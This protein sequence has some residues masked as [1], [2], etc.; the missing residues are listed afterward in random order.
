LRIKPRDDTDSRRQSVEQE[1]RRA[2]ELGPLRDPVCTDDCPQFDALAGC[3]RDCAEAPKRLSSEG[4]K[5][6][7]EPLVAPLVFEVKKLGMFEPCWSCEGHLGPTGELWKVP[8]VW[9]YSDSVI[10]VRALANAVAEMFNSKDPQKKL[11]ARWHVVLTHSDA[12]NP[13]TTFSL[14]PQWSEADKT[15]PGLQNDL[16]ILAEGL[17]KYFWEACDELSQHAR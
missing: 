11:S 13:D 7:V 6:P 10:H 5:Y 17:E 9:F 16:K 15:L 4:E 3:R 8:R 14:E 1:V 2:H 12:D